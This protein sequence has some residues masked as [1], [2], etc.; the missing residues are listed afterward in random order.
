MKELLLKCCG[1]PDRWLGSIPLDNL[2]LRP[3][4]TRCGKASLK[5]RVGDQVQVQANAEEA[6]QAATASV[7]VSKGKSSKGRERGNDMYVIVS[8]DRY[9]SQLD[10]TIQAIRHLPA[11]IT[12]QETEV[13]GTSQRL[14][15]RP[16]LDGDNPLRA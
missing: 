15:R 1:G 16:G 13:V 5:T 2:L 3:A 12:D 9:P 14:C 6:I 8:L 4:G 7:D 10:R 11:G